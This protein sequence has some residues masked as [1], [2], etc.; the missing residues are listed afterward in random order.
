M[1]D[2]TEVE[3]PSLALARARRRP[4]VPNA[5]LKLVLEMGPLILFFLA[6]KWPQIFAPLFRPLVPAGLLSGDKAGILTATCV[7]MA[8]VVAA[9]AVSYA[10][11]RRLPVMPLVTAV[12]VLVF[13]SLTLLFDNDLFIKVKPT[14]VNAIF[15]TALI[16][17]LIFGKPLLPVMLDTVLHL[18]ETG[19]RKLTLRWGLFFFLL[20][21]LNEAV[22]RTQSTDTW[23]AFKAF[24]IMPLTVV[25]ALSQVPLIMKHEAKSEKETA[26]EPNHW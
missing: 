10:I 15:G 19:W 14:L 2:K 21:A 7:L 5:G 3:T 13:G 9:L 23:V 22:W 12:A 16:G 4:A 11:T 6:D 26:N 24:G 25:F 20:A 8:S 18:T 1:T 17:G